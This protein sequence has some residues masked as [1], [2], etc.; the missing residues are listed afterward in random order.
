MLY[1]FKKG[2]HATEMQKKKRLLQERENANEVQKRFVQIME[3]VLT[4]RSHL[5]S[6]LLNGAPQFSRPAEVDSCQIK[7]LIEDNNVILHRRKLTYSKYP[8]Q[9]LKIIL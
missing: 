8:N 9:A 5:Q 7:T 4:D 1:Y 6:F 2:K 3:K